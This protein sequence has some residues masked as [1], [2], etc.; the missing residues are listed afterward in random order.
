MGF[1]WILLSIIE[2]KNLDKELFLVNS[3]FSIKNG[4]QLTWKDPS[5]NLELIRNKIN[6]LERFNLWNWCRAT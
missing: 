6:L 5:G 3:F 1:L 2:L 4:S